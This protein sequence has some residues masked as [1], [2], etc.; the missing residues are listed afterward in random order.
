MLLKLNAQSARKIHKFQ[1]L[2]HAFDTMYS[3]NKRGEKFMSTVSQ[4]YC[5]VPIDTSTR[6]PPRL[7]RHARR[8]ALSA[9]ARLTPLLAV[10]LVR[11]S[12]IRNYLLYKKTLDSPHI[13]QHIHLH[14][15][16][17]QAKN[18]NGCNSS[19]PT[20]FLYFSRSNF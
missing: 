13:Y 3:E 20:R 1:L 2:T 16:V 5:L 7:R 6:K 14:T 8:N 11:N 18:Y 17:A 19:F 15:F 10:R 9:H 12:D 4:Y